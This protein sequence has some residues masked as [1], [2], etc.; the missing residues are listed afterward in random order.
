[1]TLPSLA[2]NVHD[3]SAGVTAVS[4][5]TQVLPESGGVLGVSRP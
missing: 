5:R 3:L 4:F 2:V 1:M